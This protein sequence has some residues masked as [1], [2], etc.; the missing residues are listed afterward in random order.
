MEFGG[1]SLFTSIYSLVTQHP[2]HSTVYRH[3]RSNTGTDEVEDEHH[4]SSEE[5]DDEEN[6]TFSIN[7]SSSERE[8][9]LKLVVSDTISY[10]K[11]CRSGVEE[12]DHDDDDDD[13]DKWN[14]RIVKGCLPHRVEIQGRLDF[15]RFVVQQTTIELSFERIKALYNVFCV[16]PVVTIE[17]CHMFLSILSSCVHEGDFVTISK[18]TTQ[19]VFHDLLCA[20][21]SLCMSLEGFACFEAYFKKINEFASSM[22]IS[23]SS[24]IVDSVDLE[25]LEQLWEIVLNATD[26]DVVADASAFLVGLYVRLSSRIPDKKS[27]WRLFLDK[28]M[29]NLEKKKQLERL[30][31]LLRDFLQQVSK[32]GRTKGGG[33]DEA[34]SGSYDPR[35]VTHIYVDL[36]YED[37][38]SSRRVLHYYLRR[39]ETLRV[40]RDRIAADCGDLEGT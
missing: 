32:S 12:K 31:M 1:I 19:S 37:G 20:D 26:E 10:C 16:D 14:R 40:L 33:L 5:S 35:I 36:R 27:V 18:S 2:R 30:M 39:T 7:N 34:M 13:D 21:L 17:E 4:E 11:K 28:I 9:L 22:R 23:T 38:R 24:F 25:G 15:L 6:R 29:R 3:G 8:K